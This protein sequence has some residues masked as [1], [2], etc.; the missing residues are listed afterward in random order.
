MTIK[1]LFNWLLWDG[2]FR[3]SVMK[4]GF[5]FVDVPR[6]GSSSL[7]HNLALAFGFPH[8]KTAQG[9]LP[10]KK[11]MYLPAH[12]PAENVR[13]IIG[14]KNWEKL[15]TFSFV[16]NPY[17]RF[18]SLYNHFRFREK[19][20]NGS[21]P[22]FVRSLSD[23]PPESPLQKKPIY[24]YRQVDY[25]MDMEGN[26][27]VSFLGRYESRTS[28]LSYIIKK[29]KIKEWNDAVYTASTQK[30]EQEFDIMYSEDLRNIVHEHFNADFEAF[31]YP[32]D[33]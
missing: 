1:K 10:Y 28:D 21:F 8:G 29:L 11:S 17:V 20:W 31:K 24:A 26:R 2:Y 12:T 30:S 33:L 15:F 32:P 25:L 4:S 23:Y 16:R 5:W 22:D 19:S 27:L 6:T 7:R 13:Q 9:W 3:R 18:V 14:Q